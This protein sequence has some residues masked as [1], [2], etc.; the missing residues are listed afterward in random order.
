MFYF[1]DL[2]GERRSG[3][4]Y[5]HHKPAVLKAL[6]SGHRGMVG[7]LQWGDIC[8]RGVARFKVRSAEMIDIEVP[9]IV[10]TNLLFSSLSPLPCEAA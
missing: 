1:S 2:L 3:N 9:G 5:K 4:G 8:S 7:S 6:I 10:L